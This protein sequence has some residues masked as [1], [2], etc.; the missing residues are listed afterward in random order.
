VH[1]MRTTAA[2]TDTMTTRRVH[3]AM[4]EIAERVW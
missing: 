4:D 1:D 2:A 3:A